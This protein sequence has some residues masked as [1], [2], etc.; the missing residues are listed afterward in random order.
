MGKPPPPKSDPESTYGEDS[1]TSHEAGILGRLDLV[2]ESRNESTPRGEGRWDRDLTSFG[3]HF[4]EL[5]LFFFFSS[6]RDGYEVLF[7]F[8]LGADVGCQGSPSIDITWIRTLV[9]KLKTTP[10]WQQRGISQ[11]IIMC[12]IMIVI[13][14]E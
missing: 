12:V 8:W 9:S 5:S 11:G 1:D 7:F 13:D 6:F 2:V 14:R 3:R 4:C 10:D